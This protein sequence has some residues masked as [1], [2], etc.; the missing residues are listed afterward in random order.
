MSKAKTHEERTI[1]SDVASLKRKGYPYEVDGDLTPFS[2]SPPYGV[3]QNYLT[4]LKATS[5]LLDFRMN[6]FDPKLYIHMICE[7][8]KVEIEIVNLGY[9]IKTNSDLFQTKMSYLLGHSLVYSLD[10]FIQRSSPFEA[11]DA[12]LESL[13]DNNHIFDREHQVLHS[14]FFG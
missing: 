5:K 7:S 14:L 11:L 6:H 4:L 2:F 3:P 13:R 8:A 10:F 1:I 9:D 12:F